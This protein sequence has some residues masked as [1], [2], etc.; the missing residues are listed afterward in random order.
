VLARARSSLRGR[1]SYA[2]NGAAASARHAGYVAAQHA[3]RT[4]SLEDATRVDTFFGPL[5]MEA[6]D[7]CMPR[8]IGHF[9][10]WEPGE[11]ALL[12]EYLEP[13]MVVVDVGAHTGYFSILCGRL[14]GADGLVVAF[15]PDPRNYELHPGQRLGARADERRLP[16]VGGKRPL[17]IQR[18]SSRSREYG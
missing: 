11:T 7:P 13:G 9:G 4:P 12:E 2:S 10:I 18:A 14:V 3:G 17:W 8:Y 1:F 6:G 5:Y 16:S 15:E